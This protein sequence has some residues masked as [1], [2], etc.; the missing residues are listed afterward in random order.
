MCN[1]RGLIGARLN[2]AIYKD[3]AEQLSS[4]IS[5]M[6]FTRSRIQTFS[7]DTKKVEKAIHRM[8]KLKAMAEGN[9]KR[10]MAY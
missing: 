5:E 9:A 7:G 6:E 2:R 3:A 4:L 1:H 10:N 8:L